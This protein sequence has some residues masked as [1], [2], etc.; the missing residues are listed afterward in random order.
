M[1]DESPVAP[2][3][4][5]PRAVAAARALLWFAE[6]IRLWKRA[7]V[8]FSIMAVVVLALSFL[9]DPL[10][11]ARLLA[12]NVLAPLLAC[13]FLYSSLAVDRNSRPRVVHLLTVFA[14]P[15][16]AQLA[17]VASGLIVTGVEGATAWYLADINLLMPAPDTSALSPSSV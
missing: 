16:R 10:P 8:T 1:P 5:P 9:L 11:I 2:A 4:R 13:G 17:I 15:L 14:S 6:A 7:P 12:S 3:S